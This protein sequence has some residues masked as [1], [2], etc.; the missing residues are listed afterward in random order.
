LIIHINR[1]HVVAMRERRSP[2]PQRCTIEI[3]RPAD[4][5]RMDL[6]EKKERPRRA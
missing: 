3:R 5:S 1:S 2:N 6:K 4:R